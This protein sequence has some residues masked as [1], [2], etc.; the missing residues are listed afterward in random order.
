MNYYLF[1]FLSLGKNDEEFICVLDND[2]RYI[3]R[4][5]LISIYM[6]TFVHVKHPPNNAIPSGSRNARRGCVAMYHNHLVFMAISSLLHIE[7]VP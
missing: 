3:P 4:E 1:E 7:W 5:D 6:L 2:N